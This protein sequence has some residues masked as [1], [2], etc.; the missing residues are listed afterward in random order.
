MKKFMQTVLSG[1]ATL[2]LAFSAV[3]CNTQTSEAEAENAYLTIDINPSVEMIVADGVVTS[4]KACNDDGA[5]LLSGENFEGKTIEEATK[6]IVALAEELGY[7]TSENDDVKITA[8][9]DDEELTLKIE[10]A[11]KAGAEKGSDKAKVN[12][13]PR[14]ADQRKVKELQ[15]EN[16]ELFKKLTP[17]KVRLIEAI[18]RYDP[19]MTYEEGAAMKVDELAELLEELAKEMVDIVGEELEEKFETRFAE[20]KEEKE[21]A[22]AQIYGGEY[23]EAWQK[24][25]ELEQAYEELKVTAENIALSEDDLADILELLNLTSVEEVFA[26]DTVTAEQIEEYVDE[27]IDRFFDKGEL[28]QMGELIENAVESILEKYDAEEYILSATDLENLSALIGETVEFESL[29]ELEEFVEAQEDL[30]ED[31]LKEMQ[32]TEDQKAQIEEIKKQMKSLKEEVREGLQTEIDKNKDKFSEIKSQ[33]R[34]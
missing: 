3:A 4:V 11:A 13:D 25:V 12:A 2:A 6:N 5:V 8:L 26:S 32:L 31:L 15:A 21:A 30:L 28:A 23:Y 22:I 16:A 33:R 20:L 27:Y 9:A 10:K 7:L 18:M 19:E 1:V 29:E 17:A 34:K 24:Y 14:S